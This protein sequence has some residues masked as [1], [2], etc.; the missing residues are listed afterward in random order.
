MKPP[1]S[2]AETSLRWLLALA[3]LGGFTWGVL[4]AAIVVSAGWV[5]L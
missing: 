4:A 3:F 2:V 5:S 1:R